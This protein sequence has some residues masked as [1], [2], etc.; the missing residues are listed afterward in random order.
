MAAGSSS[1]SAVG[2]VGR[3]GDMV[4]AS[5]VCIYIYIYIYVYIQ[6]ERERDSEREAEKL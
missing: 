3:F 2:R 4:R 6:R 5:S 1:P